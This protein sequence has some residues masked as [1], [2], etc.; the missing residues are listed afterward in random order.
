MKLIEKDSRIHYYVKHHKIEE[1]FNRHVMEYMTLKV[2]DKG[3]YICR[4]DEELTDFLFF[5]KGKA[6]AYTTLKNGKDLLLCFYREFEIIGDVELFGEGRATTTMECIE[7]THCLAIPKAVMLCIIEE[8]TKVLRYVG[9]GLSNKLRRISHNS[10]V[11][12]LYPLEERLASYFLA[13]AFENQ[14]GSLIIEE[15][16]THVAEIL[17]VSYRHL[18]RVKEGFVKQG[19]MKREGTFYTLKKEDALRQLAADIY[20]N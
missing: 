3:E 19:F 20:L 9:K 17:G 18:L 13:V 11:N 6:K 1:I 14:K 12:L 10:A 15:N 7:E 4:I 8:D 2:F 16:L 5:V